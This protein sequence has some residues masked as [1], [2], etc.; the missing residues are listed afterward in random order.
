[1]VMNREHV[2]IGYRALEPA[3][4]KNFNLSHWQ[5]G[6]LGEPCL[7]VE[8]LHSCGTAACA[9]GYLALSGEFGEKGGWVSTLKGAP[10]LGFESGDKA[11]YEFY[12]ARSK[13]EKIIIDVMHGLWER[14]R[15]EKFYEVLNIVD[16]TPKM[17]QEKFAILYFILQICEG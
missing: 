2:A 14:W 8:S 5:S 17:V 9:A 4:P 10:G 13:E 11:L 7:S 6:K 1:M 15:S 12:G 16:V 3:R